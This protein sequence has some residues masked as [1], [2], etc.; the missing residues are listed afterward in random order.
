MEL[1]HFSFL[2][3]KLVI[4]LLLAFFSVAEIHNFPSKQTNEQH[5]NIYLPFETAFKMNPGE[6]FKT[7]MEKN[8]FTVNGTVCNFFH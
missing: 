5:S 6:K 2:L 1:N 8:N 7:C 3:Q 4:L